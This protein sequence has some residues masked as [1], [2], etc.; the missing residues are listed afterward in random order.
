[1]SI[2]T[3]EDFIN[4]AKAVH[5]DRYDYSKT[6]YVGSKIK[7]CV[8]CP[9]HGEFFVRPD[10]HLQGCICKKC[11]FENQKRKIFG[12]GHNDL[13]YESH[14]QAYKIW[15]HILTRCYNKQFH[16]KEPSYSKCVMCKEW[17]TF[18]NFKQWFDEHY[19][20]GWEL[21]KDILFKG[22]KEYSPDKCCFVPHEINI[23][24]TKSEAKRGDYPIGVSK[25]GSG[26]RARVLALNKSVNIGTYKTT[27][28]AF[29]AYKRAKEE[30]IR[31]IS[32]KWKEKLDHSVYNALQ[33]Y[34]VE[35]TD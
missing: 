3:T 33:N 6:S 26:F 24:F 17:L 15:K 2:C 4:K 30:Y 27:Q 21:D 28:E 20:D 10:I 29:D 25:H 16:I 31:L 11:Q 22:N 7:V 5:G 23:M 35:I 1:M 9:E 34:K 32:E 18:S 13:L 19:I 12:I 8:I 14:T